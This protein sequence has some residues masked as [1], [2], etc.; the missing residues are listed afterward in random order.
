VK[1]EDD[2]FVEVEIG[3]NK[4]TLDLYQWHND[5]LALDASVRDEFPDGPDAKTAGEFQKRVA[6]LLSAALGG[7]VS[8]R[9]ADL[10]ATATFKAV[11]DLGKA[12][13]SGPT[14]SSPAPTAPP[15]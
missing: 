3:P 8:C 9:A 15:S 10:F 12:D 13:G 1:I 5:L 7:P 11:A 4:A 6:A 14:P 2:G